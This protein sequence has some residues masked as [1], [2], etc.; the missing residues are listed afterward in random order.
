MR[1]EGDSLLETLEILSDHDLAERLLKL[2]QTIDSDVRNGQIGLYSSE[3]VFG[4]DTGDREG[5]D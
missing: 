3:E 1:Y 4:K 5:G 2:A